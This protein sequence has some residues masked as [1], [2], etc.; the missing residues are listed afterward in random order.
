[1]LTLQGSQ[2]SSIKITVLPLVTSAILGKLLYPV[3]FGWQSYR[4]G[5]G[6]LLTA[7]PTSG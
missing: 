3:C 5:Q 1:M 7:V 2:L 4:L 6:Y